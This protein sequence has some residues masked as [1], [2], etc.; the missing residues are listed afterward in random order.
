MKRIIPLILALALLAACGIEPAA[1]TPE[2][3]PTA[4]PSPSASPEPGSAAG[5]DFIAGPEAEGYTF[6][7]EELGFSLEIPDEAAPYIGICRGIP[8]F[9]PEDEAYSFYYIYGDEGQYCGFISAIIAAGRRD[10]FNP[11]RYYNSDEHSAHYPI[12]ASEEYVYMYQGGIGGYDLPLQKRE[13]QEAAERAVSPVG[14]FD[15][16]SVDTPSA[17]PEISAETLRGASETIGALGDGILTRGETASLVFEMIDAE[18]KD[19]PYPLRFTDVDPESEAARAAA[20]LDS[21]GMFA[22]YD[23]DNVLIDDGNLFRPDEPMTL[24]EFVHLLQCA[25]FARHLDPRYPLAFGDPVQADDLGERTWWERAEL[26]RAWKDGWI[27]LEDGRLRP[28]EAITCAG[29]AKALYAA[30]GVQIPEEPWS[31]LACETEWFTLRDAYAAAL[32]P[33]T[34]W[35]SYIAGRGSVLLIEPKTR[36][37]C[38]S[39]YTAEITDAGYDFGELL[40]TCAQDREPLV[41]ELPFYGD[42]TAYGI[43]LT[44]EAGTEHRLLLQ[45]GGLGPEEACPYILTEV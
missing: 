23:E 28:D 29:I 15:N 44:D 12:A 25:L 9:V 10:F 31:Y 14:L 7:S 43:S 18:N 20:Y 45:T 39:V 8:G 36:F 32:E 40:Y 11:G 13:G 37:S 38:L 21:Y 19:A 42:L 2:I 34:S 1:E 5:M 24:A 33:Y 6:R 22:R 27:R 35:N 4:A 30:A 3:T 16:L 41:I 17:L 26:D